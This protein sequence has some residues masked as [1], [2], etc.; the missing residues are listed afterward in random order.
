MFGNMNR[1][2]PSVH[3]ASDRAQRGEA[4]RQRRHAEQERPPL[5]DCSVLVRS[6]AGLA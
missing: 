1:T 3:S 2:V 6:A 4:D 5:G